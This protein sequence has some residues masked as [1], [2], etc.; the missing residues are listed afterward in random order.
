MTTKKST[1]TASAVSSSPAW[2]KWGKLVV[3]AL[4]VAI[5]IIDTTLL[6]VSLR[7]IVEDLHSNFTDI[8]WVITLYT[9]VLSAF[10]ITGGRLGDLYGRKKMFMLGAV[11][12]A[13][14]SFT[15]SISHNIG[16]LLI[17]ESIIEGIGA[18][19]ML[20]AASSLIL[21]NYEGKDRAVA[22][23]IFGAVAG[24]SSA[25]GPILGGW[26]TSAFSWR[27]GFRINIAVVAILLIGS[28][29]IKES[30]DTKEKKE[31]DLVG[32]FLTSVGLLSLVFGIIESSSYGWWTAIK[33]FT[34]GGVDLNFFGLSITPY[35][36]ALGLILI[37][38]F[39]WDQ[40]RREN[41]G[42]TP[43]VSMRLFN[44]RQFVSGMLVNTALS[45]TLT[46]LI[47]V[48]PIYYQSVHGLD[49]FH[50]GLAL[51]PLSLTVFII[52]PVS[53]VIA[54]KARP[55]T[56]I[57]AGL[58]LTALSTLTMINMLKPD[59]PST[60]L[61]PGLVLFGAGMG[62]IF[63]QVNNLTLSA[64]SGDLAGEA[65]GVNNTLRQ[66]GSSFGA[67]IIGAALF[68]NIA[69]AI[70]TNINSDIQIPQTAKAQIVEKAKTA[71]QEGG[72]TGDSGSNA[73]I[74]AE[75]TQQLSVLPAPQRAL[76]IEN[77]QKQQE[78]IGNAVK[79]DVK[80]GITDAI[81]NTLWIAF[82]FSVFSIFVGFGIPNI[83]SMM[84]D[85][86]GAKAPSVH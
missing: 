4:A 86:P 79:T 2:R 64:V 49:A 21:T 55:K 33:P 78:K 35:A 23:A 9:L 66:V 28:V 82:A 75:V 77:Y 56:M 15:A 22:F 20:P 39:I 13:V 42:H 27:W 7:N 24:A 70:T 62:L 51:F 68:T 34:V 8:Q 54:K 85:E 76:A 53:L 31:L 1:P 67:A 50:T 41:K 73:Q 3:I 80:N 26:L 25:L 12:F 44:N 30:R 32:V 63:S 47:F 46:G 48:F 36:I 43:L 81:K 60:V 40:F 6:N 65:S 38:T 17:G 72:L 37:G 19:L 16:T 84:H 18:S 11:L 61:I 29:L 74:P 57:I 59:S 58:V 69:S 10:T 14:G 52:S 83:G 5:I 45:L 71:S